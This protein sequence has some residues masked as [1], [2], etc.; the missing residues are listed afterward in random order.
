M[1][2]EVDRLRWN[3]AVGRGDVVEI[4]ALRDELLT[5]VH[6]GIMNDDPDYRVAGWVPPP[7][8]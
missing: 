5:V 6:T 8:R 1:L 7:D 2:S 3:A 4:D